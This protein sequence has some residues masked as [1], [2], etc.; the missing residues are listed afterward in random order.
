MCELHCS[1][2]KIYVSIVGLVA[3]E[4]VHLA[5]SHQHPLRHRP[6]KKLNC[7][8]R[9]NWL[10][11]GKVEVVTP[12]AA[13]LASFFVDSLRHQTHGLSN[14]YWEEKQNPY[15]TLDLNPARNLRKETQYCRALN[16]ALQR[17]GFQ[18]KFSFL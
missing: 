16:E 2:G 9:E 8:N 15:V 5:H 4:S 12:V 13:T 14:D 17:K 18:I 3:V 7:W 1:E 6:W 10:Y 11:G